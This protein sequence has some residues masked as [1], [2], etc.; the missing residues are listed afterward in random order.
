MDLEQDPTKRGRGRAVTACLE[1]RKMKKKCDRQWPCHH[2]SM[3][4]M[5]HRCQFPRMTTRRHQ[6]ISAPTE[7]SSATSSS[8]VV[9]EMPEDGSQVTSP[10]AA[11][12]MLGYLCAKD[13][14]VFGG[15]M[16]RRRKIATL[17]RRLTSQRPNTQSPRMLSLSR[18]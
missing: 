8:S 5:A 6:Q 15:I 12:R 18:F 9:A 14:A 3:R 17:R 1:C 11:T 4:K 10:A 16:V 7:M 2:C 13:D